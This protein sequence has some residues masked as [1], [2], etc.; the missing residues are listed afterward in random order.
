MS[1]R[2]NCE[3]CGAVVRAPETAAGRGGVCPQCRKRVCIPQDASPAGAS[4]DDI[5]AIEPVDESPRRAATAAVGPEQ[6]RVPLP[7]GPLLHIRFECPTCLSVIKAPRSV[8]GKKSNCPNCGERVRIPVP[9]EQDDSPIEIIEDSGP[10]ALEL[11]TDI[12]ADAPA[13]SAPVLPEEPESHV[14]FACPHC[15]SSI[16]APR[17]TAGKKSTCPSCKGRVRIPQAGGQPQTDD[18]V[19][20]VDMS[21]K[22]TSTPLTVM[23]SK[24]VRREKPRDLTDAGKIRYEC[25]YCKAII[26][27]PASAAGKKSVCPSCSRRVVVPADD[28]AISGE[29]AIEEATVKRRASAGPEMRE[30]DRAGST[31]AGREQKLPIRFACPH[32]GS[33]IKCAPQYEGKKSH[34]PNCRERIRIPKAPSLDEPRPIELL[35]MSPE[36]ERRQLDNLSRQTR[37]SSISGIL[38]MSD[39]TDDGRKIEG[40][41]VERGPLTSSDELSAPSKPR[42]PLRS[43]KHRTVKPGGRTPPER[44]GS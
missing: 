30:D 20:E 27:S 19:F 17:A 12:A 5:Y 32:C 39:S 18:D 7:S 35:E 22:A 44:S 24:E 15:G 1:I 3:H 21:E 16:K 25:P 23:D 40:E 2:F 42:E 34:C 8:A 36:E 6:P 26:R 4:G 11:K 9:D 10:R 28:G 38:I 14:H 43:G 31:A 37:G 33:V 29:I 13:P 41:V